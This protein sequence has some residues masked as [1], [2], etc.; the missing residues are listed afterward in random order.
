MNIGDFI[1]NPYYVY[2]IINNYILFNEERK[3]FNTLCKK[4]F[5]RLYEKTATTER[6]ASDIFYMHFIFRIL[7]YFESVV[8]CSDPKNPDCIYLKDLIQLYQQTGIYNMYLKYIAGLQITHQ[9]PQSGG[10]DTHPA[11][12]SYIYILYILFG[13]LATDVNTMTPVG[14]SASNNTRRAHTRKRKRKMR[15]GVRYDTIAALDK[16][17][18]ADFSIMPQTTSLYFSKLYTLRN[19]YGSC[20]YQ[21]LAIGNNSKSLA[22]IINRYVDATDNTI[23]LNKNSVG[24]RLTSDI[25]KKYVVYN[26]SD[27]EQFTQIKDNLEYESHNYM[28][29]LQEFND[30]KHNYHNRK[31]NIQYLEQRQIASQKEHL[32]FIFQSIGSQLHFTELYKTLDPHTGYILTYNCMWENVTAGHAF[33]LLYN[34]TNSKVCVVDYNNLP[35]AVIMLNISKITNIHG[36]YTTTFMYSEP[37]F[38]ENT[39]FEKQPLFNMLNKYAENPLLEYFKASYVPLDD[40]LQFGVESDYLVAEK[41]Y[42]STPH[43]MHP[44]TNTVSFGCATLGDTEKSLAMLIH[45]YNLIINYKDINTSFYLPA[46]TTHLNSFLISF[47]EYVKHKDAT[48]NSEAVAV[49]PTSTRTQSRKKRRPQGRR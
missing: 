16:Q 45:G 11:R 28:I 29:S 5:I 4:Y 8:D 49:L 7:F 10:D 41:Y 30:N 24:V 19:L 18:V 42:N 17:L 48:N 46:L 27:I 12:M 32:Q 22:S 25:F 21:S 9:T 31:H 38:W 15:G 40:T 47:V 34:T 3:I 2:E 39:D 37:G 13:I 23:I 35:H 43:V 44:F 6:K 36:M 26:K 1:D 14:G 33:N 20:V